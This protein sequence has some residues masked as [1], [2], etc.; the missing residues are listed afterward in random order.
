MP[1]SKA[2]SKVKANKDSVTLTKEGFI[3]L[4]LF[5]IAVSMLMAY[6]YLNFGGVR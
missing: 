1:K 6:A 2:R 4:I 3:G 5:V